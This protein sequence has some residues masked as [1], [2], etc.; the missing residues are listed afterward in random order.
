MELKLSEQQKQPVLFT[1]LKPEKKKKKE[2]RKSESF[3]IL[4]EH[5]ERISD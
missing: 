1:D 5:N 3:N 2:K 4:K